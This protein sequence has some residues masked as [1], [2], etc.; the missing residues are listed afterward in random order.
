MFNNPIVQVFGGPE[1]VRPPKSIWQTGKY[2][3]L[4]M[5]VRRW[6]AAFPGLEVFAA[7]EGK[8]WMLSGLDLAAEYAGYT[9]TAVD[10]LLTSQAKNIVS[11]SRYWIMIATIIKTAVTI[12]DTDMSSDLELMSTALCE[13][14]VEN[15]RGLL[16]TEHQQNTPNDPIVVLY[17]IL[18]CLRIAQQIRERRSRNRTE[19]ERIR[20]F[21][22]KVGA[23][24]AG[25]TVSF[26]K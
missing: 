22:G 11:N 9:E 3:S 15:S 20:L 23:K 8:R 14:L 17:I 7:D 10:D 2:I 12:V 19:K 26:T 21:Y 5:K 1:E 13:Y 25:E 4:L 16:G 18:I 6:Y 24:L